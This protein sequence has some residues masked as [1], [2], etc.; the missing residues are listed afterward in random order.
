M[1]HIREVPESNLFRDDIPISFVFPP[2]KC[3]NREPVSMRPSTLQLPFYFIIHSFHGLKALLG[4][5]LII[6]KVSKSHSDTTHS[7]GLLRTSTTV[8]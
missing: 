1:V 5:G 2:G 7:V 4:Q 8:R 3:R 6:L